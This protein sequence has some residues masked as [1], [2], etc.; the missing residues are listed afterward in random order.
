MEGNLNVV[1]TILLIRA[2]KKD[3]LH[4]TNKIN[5]IFNVKAI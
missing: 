3:T 1:I 5:S 2:N 4:Q